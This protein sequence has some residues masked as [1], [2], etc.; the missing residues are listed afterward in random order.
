MKHS[1]F[2]LDDHPVLLHGLAELV[3]MEPDFRVVGSMTDGAAAFPAI[4]RLKP[5]IVVLDIN[6]P[7]ISGLAL[8]RRIRMANLPV[9][10]VFLTALITPQQLAEAIDNEIWGVVLKEAAPNTLIDC[11]RSVARGQQ[12][13]PE[14]IAHKAGRGWR[15]NSP[16][17]G[18]AALT[19]REME[20]AVQACRGLSNRDIARELGAGEGTVKIHLH[21][22]FQKLRITNRTALAAIYFEGATISG[23]EA[24]KG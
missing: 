8:L 23:V 2:L 24:A 22:I 15:D 7:D 4:D 16:S 6:M 10:T 20:I 14:E 19:P 17:P 13:L 3:A 18:L 1:V 11:L 9:R 21:N 12:W 5:D